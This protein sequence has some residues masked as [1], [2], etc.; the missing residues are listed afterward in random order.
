MIGAKPVRLSLVVVFVLGLGAELSAAAA[1]DQAAI[2]PPSPALIQ[3]G[4]ELFARECAACHGAE[5]KGDGPASYLLYP[6]PRNFITS[7]FRIVSTWERLPTDQDLFNTITRGMPG[8]SMPPWERFSEDQRWSLVYFIKSLS[9]RPWP[10][11]P[12]GT[13]D[14]AS[15][16]RKGVIAVPPEPEYNEA[17][18]QIAAKLYVEGCAPCH[19]ATGRGDGQQKQIDQEG[20]PTRPR[21][22]TRGIYKGVPTS[23]EVYRR[24]VAG[25]PGTPMPMSDWSYG[26]QAW[27]LTHYVMGLSSEEQRA[28]VVAR[29]KTVVAVRRKH[30]PDH[31]DSAEW[32]GAEPVEVV[33]MP[34]W[35]RDD[36]AQR[37]TVRAL[38]DGKNIVIQLTW[39]DAT[40]DHTAIRPQDFRDAAA[41]QMTAATAPPF[42]GMGEP[43]KPVNIW[44]WKSERQADLETAFQDLETVYPNIGTDSYPN[45]MNSP[46]EQPMRHALTLESDPTFVTGWGAGN[47]VS[48]PT[49]RRSAESLE[50]HGFGSLKVRPLVDQNVGA[51]GIYGS[52]AYSVTFKRPLQPKGSDKLALKPG[53]TYSVAFAVWDGSAG[54]R[55]GKKCVTIW[56]EL[57]LQP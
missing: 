7:E 40:N 36:F 20:F 28:A 47:I 17:A 23:E 41:V 56:H 29:R 1:A 43:G 22:L 13:N 49:Y 54:D 11:T 12:K 50:A 27:H 5:G 52:S 51:E 44:M 32:R 16:E 34:L 37:V 46:L 4:K 35:W 2:P 39:P 18:K 9:D 24:I 55:D 3:Q 53:A 19:G 8:S 10:Q 30:I 38:H 25:I 31:P 21:D 26:E 15:Q 42:I 57:K 14:T 6:K 48:D 45:L 33:T